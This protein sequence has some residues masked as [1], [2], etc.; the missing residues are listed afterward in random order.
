[1]GGAEGPLSTEMRVVVTVVALAAVF[2]AEAV[3]LQGELKATRKLV[4]LTARRLKHAQ[5][6]SSPSSDL[7]C[8]ACK[9]IVD[10]LDELFRENKTEDEIVDVIT[11][12]CINLKIED[13]NVCTLV[14][15]EFKVW[16]NS[17]KNSVV[18]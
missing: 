11:D 8:D 15:K 18:Y 3:P 17:S 9:I 1:M 4:V 14:V 7:T 13:R 6:N 12:I 10:E 16:H 2:L 5:W